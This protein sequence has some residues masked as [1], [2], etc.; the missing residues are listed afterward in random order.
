MELLD[1]LL[2]LER[3]GWEALVAGNGGAYYRQRLTADAVM[4]FPFGVLN[5]EETIE[6]MESAPPWAQFE[7]DDARAVDL[8][9]D[10]GVLIY[11]VVAQRPGQDPYS[12]VISSTFVRDGGDWKLAFHQQSPPAREG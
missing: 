10:G 9:A 11:R 6:A 5:R 8:G 3:E 7:I 2:A 1:R 12:A 4:A